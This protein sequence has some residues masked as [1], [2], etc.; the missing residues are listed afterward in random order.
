MN[1]IVGTLVVNPSTNYLK[2]GICIP[3]FHNPV[4]IGTLTNSRVD[5]ARLRNLLAI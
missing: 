1:S 5:N 2:C 3:Y 4:S